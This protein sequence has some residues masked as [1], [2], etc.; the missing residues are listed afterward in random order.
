M[1]TELTAKQEDFVI[2]SGMERER[3]AREARADL[4]RKY[5]DCKE[6]D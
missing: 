6:E 4:M 5:G 2:E 1:K 3:E